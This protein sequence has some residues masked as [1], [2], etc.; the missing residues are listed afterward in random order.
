MASP[1]PGRI[2]HV[3]GL[4]HLDGDHYDGVGVPCFQLNA[5]DLVAPN[6][7]RAGARWADVGCGV[8]AV[9][10]QA[11]RGVSPGTAVG[12]A[13]SPGMLERCR[14]AVEQA[15]L[16]DVRLVLDDAQAPAVDGGPF[17]TLSSSL[18]L[19]FLPDPAAAL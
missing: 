11:A 8:G 1:P 17:D 18:V 5:R 19:F 12:T 7:P 9:L 15:G 3:A 6:P 16:G 13:L 14:Q 4:I 10:V 2:Q